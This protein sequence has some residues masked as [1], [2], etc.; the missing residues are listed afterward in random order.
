MTGSRFRLLRLHAEGG[1]GS[2]FVA[3]DE[4]LRREVAIKTIK[5]PYIHD[6]V[7]RERF[8]LEAEITGLLEHPGIVPVY[9]MGRDHEHRPYYAMRL[10]KGETL[11]E[12]IRRFHQA[13][14]TPGRVDRWHS[15]ELRQLLGRFVA[16]CNTVAYAHSRGVIHRDLKPDNVLLG[17]YGETLVA[18]WGL[19]KVVGRTDPRGPIG[20]T[21]ADD[22]SEPTIRPEAAGMDPTRGALG[23]PQYMSPEQAAAIPIGSAPPPTSTA[24][25]LSSIESSPAALRWQRTE[26]R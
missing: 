19:A 26:S 24:W 20:P 25:E 23:T 1:R 5:Q 13:D 4:E 11:K 3:H 12:A 21:H 18:D 14:A 9:S 17:P 8:L 16:V 22:T 10:I 15:L 6:P 2:V 7:S